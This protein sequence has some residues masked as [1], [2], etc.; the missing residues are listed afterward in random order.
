MLI[1]FDYIAGSDVFDNY[2]VVETWPL[3]LSSASSLHT[4]ICSNLKMYYN[5]ISVLLLLLLHLHHSQI[6][7]ACCSVCIG[8]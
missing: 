6:F 4:V 3:A 2:H 7:P 5:L 1:P 8:K